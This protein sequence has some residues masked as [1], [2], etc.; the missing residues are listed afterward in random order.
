[1]DRGIDVLIIGAGP[2]GMMAGVSA[3]NDDNDVMILEKNSSAGV[4]LL[5]TGKGRCN[6]TTTKEIDEIVDAFGSLGKFLYGSLSR[7]SNKDIINFFE[8]RGVRL[9]EE[10]G[11]RVF[12]KSDNSQDILNCLLKE[13]KDKD[14]HI[15]YST[16]VRSISKEKDVFKVRTKNND[17]RA[18]KIIIAT[19]GASYPQTGSTGDGYKFARSFGH[20][21]IDPIPALTPLLTKDRNVNE[22]AGLSLKNVEISFSSE[23]KIFS[24]E[25]GEMLFTHNGLSG[26]IV[27]KCSR[28]VYEHLNLGKKVTCRID[29]RPKLNEKTLRQSIIRKIND[30][31]KKEY[32]SLLNSLFPRSLVLYAASWTGIDLHQQSSTLTKQQL[33]A[34]IKFMKYFE[35][36]I[37]GVESIKRSIV[38]H[39]GVDI[40]E[41]D[42]R[43]M[44]S[45]IVEGLYFAGEIICL[46][47]PSGG[48]NIT[49]AL[50]TGYVAGSFAS[51]NTLS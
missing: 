26:P 14:V 4:K 2:A 32:K 15:S 39:G 24:K 48:F 45:K 38:T 42:S 10:R 13:L 23:E 16:P 35:F 7:F 25:F 41:I 49:K 18:K 46:D 22:L 40:K 3:K 29:L 1:M 43:T 44:G 5:L 50:S 36:K 9:K 37:E 11:Q 19:G 30:T 27:L 31:P 47:G 34:L 12:P 51:M 21:I 33:D 8:S 20:K 28:S 6:V 17:F